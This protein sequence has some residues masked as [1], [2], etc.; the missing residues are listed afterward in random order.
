MG[1]GVGV[2]K[3]EGVGAA[4]A[5]GAGAEVDWA[6][7]YTGA[8]AQQSSVAESIKSSKHSC[9]RIG[10]LSQFTNFF[11][12]LYRFELYHKSCY[13]EHVNLTERM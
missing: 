10:H 9:F 3:G 6:G 12:Y 7:T 8:H 4:V 2:G 5:V 13:N 1:A 11:L